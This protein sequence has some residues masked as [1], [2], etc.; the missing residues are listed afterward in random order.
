MAQ[1]YMTHP[2]NTTAVC[3]ADMVGRRNSTTDNDPEATT[4]HHCLQWLEIEE[5]LNAPPLCDPWVDPNTLEGPEY[6][7]ADHVYDVRGFADYDG[8]PGDDER[9]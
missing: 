5:E 7:M 4:C 6:M 9:D 8:Y 3:G 2:T 1:H